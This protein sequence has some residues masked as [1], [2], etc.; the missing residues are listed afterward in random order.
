MQQPLAIFRGKK[1][2]Y[3]W[4][5]LAGAFI[6]LFFNAICFSLMGI[7]MKPVSADL[8]WSRSSMDT[9]LLVYMI[10]HAVS[11]PVCGKIYDRFGPKAAII[12]FSAFILAGNLLAAFTSNYVIFIIAYGV[13]IGIGMGGPANP[14]FAALIC[15]WFTKYRGLAI[16]LA[17]SGFC[18][19]LFVLVPITNYLVEIFHWRPAFIVIGIVIF[20]VNTIITLLIIKGDP[21][22]FGLKPLGADEQ[23]QK[24]SNAKALD[25]SHDL[26]LTTALKT[27][28]FWLMLLVMTVCGI[29]CTFM[30]AYFIP[31]ATDYGVD[32]TTAGVIMGL[33]G[34]YAFVGM[35]IGGP[36]ADKFGGRWPLAVSMLFRVVGFSVVLFLPPLL[37]FNL[38]ALLMTLTQM[39]TLPISSTV[40]ANMFGTSHMGFIT[41]IFTTGHHG[42]GAVLAL[43]AGKMFMASGNYNSVFVFI[44]IT[45]VVGMAAAML[46]KE[47]RYFV[48]GGNVVQEN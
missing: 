19:G 26:T 6:I 14:L 15:K 33:T 32:N 17:L 46:I 11:V 5:V 23:I 40:A 31:A 2:Y 38:L 4:F 48:E 1:I 34:L 44:V 7:M 37:S 35:L 9:A 16:S 28:G 24:A 12:I 8:G 39:A 42:G 13:L 45:A 3:G 30:M 10:V 21:K 43:V 29:G 22:D 36:L 47:K 41:G 25:A 27:R 18:A 20:V